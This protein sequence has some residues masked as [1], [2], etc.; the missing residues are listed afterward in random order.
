MYD[1]IMSMHADLPLQ[2]ATQQPVLLLD[3]CGRLAHVHLDFITS[4]EAFMA[5]LKVR[6]QDAGQRKIERGQF[7]L[8]EAGSR[9]AIDLRRPWHTCFLPGQKVNMSMIFSQPESIET[10]CPDCHYESGRGTSE[11]VDWYIMKMSF[12]GIL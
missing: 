8:E 12:A 5:V 11:D 7:I 10:S 2:R 9:R 3:A 1:M 4:A 6:F